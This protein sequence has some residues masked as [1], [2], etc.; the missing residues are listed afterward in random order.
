MDDLWYKKNWS[1]QNFVRRK[2]NAISLVQ[3]LELF[4]N[5]IEAPKLEHLKY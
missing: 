4:I 3:K 5:G 2:F 1:Q